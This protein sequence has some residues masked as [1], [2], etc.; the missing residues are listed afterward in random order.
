MDS[1]YNQFVAMNQKLLDCY[2]KVNPNLYIKMDVQ[3]Q[4]DICFSERMQLEEMLV[5]GKLQSRDFF[6]AAKA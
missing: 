1:K 2:S 4:K 3:T 5:K 6:A